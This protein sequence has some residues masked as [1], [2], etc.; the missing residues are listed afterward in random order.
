MPELQVAELLASSPVTP[1]AH[2][3]T[4]LCRALRAEPRGV[5]PIVVFDTEAGP[6]LVDG[7]HRVAAAQRRGAQTVT[8]EV[9]KGSRR[10]AVRYAAELATVQRGISRED[11]LGHIRRRTAERW[12]QEP[13]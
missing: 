1:D 11:A 12:G 3:D 7:Y 13:K 5:A 10:D 9:R 8:A 4:E 2:L 6:L